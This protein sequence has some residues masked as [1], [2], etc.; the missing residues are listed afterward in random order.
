MTI[1]VVSDLINSVNPHAKILGDLVTIEQK[2]I[3]KLRAI[4]SADVKGYSLLMTKDEIVTIKTL[5]KYRNIMSKII[6]QHSGRVVDAPGDNMLAEFSSAV[7]AVQCS[8]KIQKRLKQK[9]ED[10]PNDKRIEFRVGINIGD[11]IQD[12][13]SLYGEGVNI[14]ARI[15]GLS[16]PGGVCISRNTYDHIKNKLDLH[17]AYIGEKTVKNIRGPIRV[18]KV[19]M[20]PKNS[21]EKIIEKS[22]PVEFDLPKAP[23]VAVLP[24]LNMSDDPKQEYFSDG[25][26]EDLI[27]DLSKISGLL[28]TSR[29]SAFAFKGKSVEAKQI[30]EKLGVRYLLEGS[31]RKAGEQLR[32]NAQLIDATTDHHLWAERYDGKMDNIF[33][34]QDK[35][36]QKIVAALEVKLAK[37][38]QENLT[39]RETNNIAA[40]DAFLKGMNYLNQH[41][42]TAK[43]LFYFEKAVKLD[44]DYGRAYI[45]LAKAYEDASWFDLFVRLGISFQETRLWMHH[46]LKLAMKKPTAFAIVLNAKILY[47]ERR[48]E[49]AILEI[50][51][52]IALEPNDARSNW[53]MSRALTAGG[54]PEEGIEYAKHALRIDPNC[55]Y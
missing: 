45:G 22:E 27:T 8:V 30:A 14:A 5:K 42:Q 18:Y 7:E 55:V 49:E 54:R 15:E 29:N 19:L 40:Y 43:A 17:Y 20:D 2:V 3:R 9:N 53:N 16:D 4:F 32:I 38:E 34:L 26:T 6:K 44:P 33:D 50:E 46:Y 10:L 1:F 24:F 28:V 37:G 48:Y 52:A 12:G 35:I 25:I 31:V 21:E 36:T 13:G 47:F 51:R 11:V 23:S 39:N 41:S